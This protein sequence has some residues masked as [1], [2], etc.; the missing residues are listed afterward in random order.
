MPRFGSGFDNEPSIAD[1]CF[2]SAVMFADKIFSY[3]S[4]DAFV[5]V[6]YYVLLPVAVILLACG[7]AGAVKREAQRYFRWLRHGNG[8]QPDKAT[9]KP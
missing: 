4:W 9:H 7:Y 1:H 8:E 3:W 6:G 2:A 5:V